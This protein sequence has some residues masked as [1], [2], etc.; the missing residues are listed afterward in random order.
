MARLQYQPVGAGAAAASAGDFAGHYGFGQ[1]MVPQA[2]ATAGFAEALLSTLALARHHGAPSEALQRQ[3][4]LALAA[5]ARD[6]LRA[7]NSYL[8]RSPARAAGGIR[9]SLVEPEIRIDFV[10][11]A[12][13]ALVRGQALGIR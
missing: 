1:L 13:S 6:Q 3:A 11:H 10:Q 2:P 8:M 12:A 9:R 7:D 5:L 4:G